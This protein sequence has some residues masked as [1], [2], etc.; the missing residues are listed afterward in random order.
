MVSKRQNFRWRYQ[1]R[2]KMDVLMLDYITSNEFRSTK[3]MILLALRAFWLPLAVALSSSL[4]EATKRRVVTEACTTLFNQINQIY[5][6][7]GFVLPNHLSWVNQEQFV[8]QSSPE[9]SKNKSTSNLY[10]IE[11]QK[12]AVGQ[13]DYD[14]DSFS[15]W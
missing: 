9:Q 11:E 6:A 2:N 1:P 14:V 13:F 8:K 7:A 15:S 10:S 3:E 12:E 5:A 4:D